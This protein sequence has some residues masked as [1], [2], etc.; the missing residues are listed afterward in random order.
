MKKSAV[1]L[2][3]LFLLALPARAME[4]LRLEG[5]IEDQNDRNKSLAVINGEMYKAGDVL[6]AFRVGEIGSNY[7]KLMGLKNGKEEQ[8]LYVK[9]APKPVPTEPPTLV[10]RAKTYAANP[11]L[12]VKRTWEL[13]AIRDLSIINNAS[14]KYFEK[15]HFFPTGLRQLTMDGFL[16][17]AYEGGK[18]DK[19]QFYFR[20]KPQQ[21]QDL[22]LHADPIETNAGLLYFFVGADAVIR[23]SSDKPANAQSPVHR[24]IGGPSN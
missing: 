18:V 22:Q 1:F 11:E 3:F 7:A 21:P 4:D 8:V 24:Y 13:K 2:L 15:N 5:V 9:E 10:D 6:G 17:A 12:A 16:D 20:N 23:E 14:V 19:Y